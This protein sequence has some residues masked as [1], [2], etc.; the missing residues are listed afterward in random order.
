MPSSLHKKDSAPGRANLST[1]WLFVESCARYLRLAGRAFLRHKGCYVAATAILALGI[2]MSVAM[3]S[4]VDAVLL[5]PLPF[6][7]QESIYV[8]WK[9]DPLAGEYVEELAYPE[10]VDLQESIRGFE[11]V[12]VLPTSLYGYARVL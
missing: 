6:P 1:S 8:I 11:H 2:G 9:A 12:A 10:L 5:S 4:V 7:E 3:C